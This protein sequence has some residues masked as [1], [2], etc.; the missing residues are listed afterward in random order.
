MYA[1]W[2]FQAATPAH[3]PPL[4]G[5]LVVGLGAVEVGLVVD[6]GLGVVEVE[7]GLGVV[8]VGL[9]DEVVGGGGGG[10]LPTGQ[11]V[12]LTVVIHELAASGYSHTITPAVHPLLCACCTQ[13]A[14]DAG[15]MYPLLAS[16]VLPGLPM[17]IL[18]SGTPATELIWKTADEGKV[19]EDAVRRPAQVVYSVVPVE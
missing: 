10:E 16:P 17:T 6:V 3:A 15:A 7:V 18:L 19:E 9:G 13:V 5:A 4:L 1:V 12:D 11:L 2:E 14:S 8:L